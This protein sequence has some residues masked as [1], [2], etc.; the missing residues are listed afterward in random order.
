MIDFNEVRPATRSLATRQPTRLERRTLSDP[1]WALEVEPGT[2]S[3]YTDQLEVSLQRQLGSNFAVEATGI[4]KKT[5]DFIALRPYD[6]GTGQFYNWTSSPFKTWTGYDTKVW[7]IERRDYTGDGKFDIDDAKYVLNHIKYRAVNVDEFDGKS[8]GRDFT[9][10][11]LVFTK[12]YSNRW[13]GLGSI[14]WARS[15]GIA[16]RT[17]DQNWFIDGPMVMDTPFGSSYNHFQNNLEG[18]MLMTPQWMAK[19]S[20]SYMIPRIET[21]FGLRYRFDSGRPF[22][23]LQT[24]PTFATWMSSLQNGVYLG[25]GGNDQLVAADPNHPDYGPPTS[26][27]DLNLTKELRFAK[28]YGANISFDVLNAFNENAP[29]RIGYRQGD[30]GR[31]YS[32]V[33]PRVYRAGVK[34]IF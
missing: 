1:S 6:S 8:V 4:Y 24:I 11:Q 30:Y 15:D 3:P 31:V 7:E 27:F 33:S 2:G 13:Q 9:G 18:P 5:K 22:F 20:G 28:G 26:I 17:V 32:L 23:P 34:L 10:L 14:N 19:I 12:R 21:N 25:T 16:P 29:N